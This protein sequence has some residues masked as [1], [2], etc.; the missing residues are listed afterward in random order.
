[1]E[2]FRIAS[3]RRQQSLQLIGTIARKTT[4]SGS[5]SRGRGGTGRTTLPPIAG[6]SR[7]ARAAQEP[8][9]LVSTQTLVS[10]AELHSRSNWFMPAGDN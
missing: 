6:V 1:M 2:L 9:V 4:L 5:V 10:G 3:R 8:A 7:C